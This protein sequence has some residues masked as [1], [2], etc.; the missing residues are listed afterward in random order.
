MVG[1][2]LMHGL[3]H[4]EMG[5]ILLPHDRQVDPFEGSCPYHG[6][7]FE[8][9]ASG[10]ALEKR[11]GHPG[12]SL[13]PDHPAW[14]I[15]AGY[16]GA[17]LANLILTLSPQRVLLGGG[18]MEQRHLLPMVRKRV[19]DLLNGYVRSPAIQQHIDAYVV[20]PALGG[21]AGVLGAIALA[22]KALETERS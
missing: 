20:P 3:I 22:R 16:I 11:W 4:P 14:E 1:G 10:P 12:E 13:P 2:Q 8:G 19:V 21:Q 17:G 5:H 9:L 15:E 6:D 18:V 7:C